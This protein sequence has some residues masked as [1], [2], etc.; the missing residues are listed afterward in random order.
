MGRSALYRSARQVAAPDDGLD[1]PRRGRAGRRPDVRW[2]VDRR[3]EG[4]QRKR[5]DPEAG[6]RCGLHRPIQRDADD[7]R[8]LRHRRTVDRRMVRPRPA[9]DRQARREFPQVDRPR[10]HRLCRPRSRV[11][12]V[13]RREVLR[14]LRR[15]GLQARR[16]RTADQH[17]P[18]LRGGQPRPPSA[19]QGR[20]FPRR[21]GRQRG[22]HPRRDGLD[23]DR[24]GPAVRQAPPRGGRR[25]AR[26]RPH[27]RH[28]RRNRRPDAD[29]Q[30]RRAPGR[31]RLRQVGD[32]HAQADQGR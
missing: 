1:R 18:R 25:P 7:D 11:L 24:D 17:R 23:D 28:A 15:L 19:R 26:A 12:H 5:H 16:H 13:R 21:A 30:V 6:P 2:L 4:H 31:S 20:L 14:R 29:L 22:R 8:L 27:F 3:L 32:F 9:Y 10:R